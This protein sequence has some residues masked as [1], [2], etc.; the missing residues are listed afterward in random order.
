MNKLLQTIQEGEKE[1]DKKWKRIESTLKSERGGRKIWDANNDDE[2]EASYLFVD[3]TLKKQNTLNTNDIL[4]TIVD[5]CEEGK[6]ELLKDEPDTDWFYGY[7]NNTALDTI[8]KQLLE[9]I[10][11][12]D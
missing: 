8:K 3:E 2:D 12:Y 1:F 9:I 11:E 5:M 10:K 7:G 4:Y 6:M